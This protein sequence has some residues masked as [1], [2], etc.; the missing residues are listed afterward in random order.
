MGFTG[1]RSMYSLLSS[2]DALG[3][4]CVVAVASRGFK[5]APA[6]VRRLG[7][8][9]LPASLVMAVA[10]ELVGAIVEFG[11]YLHQALFDTAIGLVFCWLVAASASGFPGVIGRLLTARP[12]LY[13]GRI[14]YGIYIYHVLLL[15][16][17]VFLL[18]PLALGPI[19]SGWA[20]LLAGTTLTIAVAS[21]SWYAFERPINELRRHFPYLGR[22]GTG[23]SRKDVA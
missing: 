9:V 2:F 4:G 18:E 15:P 13:C 3:L 6:L 7:T 22:D 12:L 19:A 5:P 21:L 14:A 10:L 8:T 1:P 20:I 23:A 17:V 11:G 16:V